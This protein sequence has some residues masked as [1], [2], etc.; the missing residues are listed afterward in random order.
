LLKIPKSFTP[1]TFP[2]HLG[3]AAGAEIAAGVAGV[4]AGSVIAIGGETVDGVTAERGAVMLI[5]QEGQG[6]ALTS[7]KGRARGNALVTLS[8]CSL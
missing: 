3:N 6:N 2:Y 1:L 5:G 4:E 7:K 8:L